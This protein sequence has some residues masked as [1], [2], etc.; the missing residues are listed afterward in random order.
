MYL[1]IDNGNFGFDNKGN[2][3]VKDEDY[4]LFFE[5]QSNGKQFRLKE[6]PTGNQLFDYIEE[7]IPEDV[8]S[9]IHPTI[10]ERVH[11]LEMAMLEAL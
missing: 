6:V 1:V 10:E 8:D 5:E 11:A 7:Y 2:I 9:K 4:K 3:P